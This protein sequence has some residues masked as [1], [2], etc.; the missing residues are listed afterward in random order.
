MIV[1]ELERLHLEFFFFF[2]AELR[3]L[4]VSITDLVASVLAFACI[5]SLVSTKIRICSKINKWF[6]K[7][8]WI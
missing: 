6:S 2:L 1:V 5:K 8:P 4:N 7:T 3:L